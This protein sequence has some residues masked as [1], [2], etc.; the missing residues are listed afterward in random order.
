MNPYITAMEAIPVSE[1]H[2]VPVY[3]P[4]TREEDAPLGYD[5]DAIQTQRESDTNYLVFKT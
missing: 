2:I 3:N 5:A 1:P 4:N